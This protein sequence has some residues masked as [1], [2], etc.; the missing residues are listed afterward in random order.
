MKNRFFYIILLCLL[1][2][3]TGSEKKKSQLRIGQFM[4]NSENTEVIIKKKGSVKIS[5]KLQ[6][7]DLTDYD[8][9]ESGTYDIEVYNAGQIILKKTIGIGTN[10]T[11][12]L[13]IY[14]IPV[15]S[16]ELNQRSTKTKLLEM[17]QGS[18][19]KSTNAYLPQ[20]TILNDEFECGENEAKIR[21]IHLAPGVDKLSAKSRDIEQDKT[22]RLSTLGYPEVSK[23][24]VLS[25]GREKLTWSLKGKK[26]KVATKDIKT[27]SSILYTAF[28]LG[29]ENS[30]ISNLEIKIATSPKKEF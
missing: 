8:Q 20:L 2:A 6:Y 13:I 22:T 3:C 12:T 10:D 4:I 24:M 26:V 30:Y 7:K 17:V 1:T 23:N 14:G 27:S 16:Q 9:V 19:V 5:K 11:Y 29:E 28:V 15:K 18:E 25:P 21:W